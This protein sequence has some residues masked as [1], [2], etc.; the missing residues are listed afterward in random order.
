MLEMVVQVEYYF[1][2]LRADWTCT[3][4]FTFLALVSSS[5]IWG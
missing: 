2:F 4:H 5:V 3:S 1:D